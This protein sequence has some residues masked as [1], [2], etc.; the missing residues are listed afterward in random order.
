ML[1]F[2]IPQD[3]GLLHDCAIAPCLNSI[4]GVSAP[5][6]DELWRLR[7]SEAFYEW[8]QPIMCPSFTAYVGDEVFSPMALCMLTQLA[9][10]WVGG[11]LTSGD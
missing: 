4:F 1:D 9:P 2:H 10:G 3:I 7:D 8:L 5:K 6:K 11:A